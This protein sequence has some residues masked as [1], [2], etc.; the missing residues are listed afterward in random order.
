MLSS[1][2][3][4]ASLTPQRKNPEALSG[5]ILAKQQNIPV[6]SP[7]LYWHKNRS[8][9]VSPRQEPLNIC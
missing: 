5:K 4:R 9:A 2:W 8:I 7:L 6:L 3:L 1:H